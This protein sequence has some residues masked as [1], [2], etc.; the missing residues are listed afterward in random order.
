MKMSCWVLAEKEDV[1]QQQCDVDVSW[2]K[3]NGWDPGSREAKMLVS[4]NATGALPPSNCSSSGELTSYCVIESRLKCLILFVSKR[5]FR[6]L[7]GVL[8][9]LT[10]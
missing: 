8:I 10:T 1:K 5:R 9:N 2:W 7:L 4:Q 6:L 3:V